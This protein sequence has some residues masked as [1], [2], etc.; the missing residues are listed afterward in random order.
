L[1]ISILLKKH[2]GK[3]ASAGWDGDRYAVFEDANHKLGLVWVSTWDSTDDAREFLRSYAACQSE[4]VEN[5]GGV[6][7]GEFDSVWRNDGEAL[8]VIERHG[9]DVI[10]IEGFPAEPTIALLR[11]AR[12]AKKNEMKP[13]ARKNDDRG[14]TPGTVSA[15]LR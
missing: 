4:K 11:A 3:T 9:C 8:H 6:P 12:E 5:L 1:Q 10:V 2:N 7:R 15:S 13:S 14:K